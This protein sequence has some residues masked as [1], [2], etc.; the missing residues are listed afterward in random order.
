MTAGQ[1]GKERTSYTTRFGSLAN[2]EKGGVEIIN[3]DPRHYA[4]SNVFEIASSA[5]PYEKTAVGKNMEYVVEA[6][7]AEGTSGWRTAAHD[8]FALVLDGEVEISLVK[9]AHSPLAPDAG[10]SVA[11]DGEPEGQPMGR[12]VARRGHMALLP[13]GSAYRFRA[14][15]PGV[16][17]QQTIAGPDTLFRWS[18]ICQSL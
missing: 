8:E 16:I 4:F 18:E 15:Q 11:L 9:L 1:R 3:D 2:Y 6:I 10:G 14:D 13:A 5:A 17:L 7:R 12:I